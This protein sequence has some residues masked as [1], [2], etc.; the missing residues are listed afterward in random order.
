MSR[1]IVLTDELLQ[2][3]QEEFAEKVKSMKLFN[4]KLEYTQTF[5]WDGPEGDRASVYMSEA[6]FAKMSALVQQF[7]SEVAWYGEVERDEE[8]PNTFRVT[9]ILV[10][11]QI[12][13]ATT[14]DID[15]DRYAE[16]LTDR[17][18]GDGSGNRH[19]Q[20]HS[21]VKMGVAPSY[22][23]LEHQET[24]LDKL[25]PDDFYIFII[26]NQ[27]YDMF[28]RI[29]DMKSNTMYDTEDIDVFVGGTDCNINDFVAD[30]KKLVTSRSTS[31]T[32]NTGGSS[33]VPA[34]TK[35]K[36]ANRKDLDRF[37]D[38]GYDDYPGRRYG[39]GSL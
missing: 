20:G 31:Y 11:P 10:Y 33:S 38:W 1:P 6:A 7:D 2:K 15:N 14:V 4:G 3:V 39:Y 36:C 24:V 13:T 12:V 34:K 23:D 32:S 35:P 19:M 17:L 27:R 18:A 16:W 28:I 9:D 8:S 30:A 29:F 21:H 22:D 26:C 37:D 25:G 5:K